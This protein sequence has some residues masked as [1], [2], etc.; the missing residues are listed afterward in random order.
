VSASGDASPDYRSLEWRIALLSTAAALVGALT[1]GLFTYLSTSKQAHSEAA[2]ARSQFLASQR[3]VAYSQFLA[4]I[5]EVYEAADRLSERYRQAALELKLAVPSS[6]EFDNAVHVA[7]VQGQTVRLISSRAVGYTVQG[8]MDDLVKDLENQRSC[9]PVEAAPAFSAAWSSGR[10]DADTIR[11]L[12]QAAVDDETIMKNNMTAFV[13]AAAD[14][15][16]IR[17]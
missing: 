17:D 14:D 9:V 6:S 15:L 12:R 3:Q 13:A 2:L 8:I 1:G 7:R 5:E 4:N 10:C 16:E 11:Q